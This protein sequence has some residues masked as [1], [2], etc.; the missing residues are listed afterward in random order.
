MHAEAKRESYIGQAWL[1]ILLGALYGAA[2]AGVETTLGPRIA[3]NKRGEIYQVIP[4]LVADADEANTVEML[5]DAGDGRQMLV[6]KAMAADGTHQGWVVP[7][8]GQGF[9]DRIELLIGLDVPLS[10][11]TGLYVLD[12]KETPGLGNYITGE[13]FR[14]QFSGKSADEPLVV[15]KSP[16]QADNEIRALSGATIS[17][18]SVSMIV[19]SAIADVKTSIRD[20]ARTT[21]GSAPSAPGNNR[22]NT[23]Q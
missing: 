16:P 20:Q 9:N 10:T 22:Q 12:Q 14:G 23:Q 2:L 3:Q 21:G 8:D 4:Q 11:I 19:N 18:E 13:S 15:V 17:S 1:V 7:A 5:V 6:Y